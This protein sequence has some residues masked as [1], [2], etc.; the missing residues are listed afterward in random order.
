MVSVKTTFSE[1]SK[2]IEEYY[3]FINT[4]IATS[5]NDTLN[6][7]LKSNLLLMLYNLVEST[8]SN[9]V[10]EIH[11]SI[12]VTSTSFNSLKKEIRKI[13]IGYLKSYLNPS[14]FVDS[15]S[16]IS[17]DIIKKC[18]IKQKI[19]SGN[20]D[21]KK[22]RELSAEYGFN[23]TTDYSKTKNGNC[24]L[25]IKGKRNDLAHGV[26]S[27]TEVG[28]DYSIMDL[29]KMKDETINYL[30]EI[31]TNIETYLTNKEYIQV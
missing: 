9:A 6:K 16:D 11:N 13:L 31:L 27:F 21:G 18:F 20:I 15:I 24:L 12:H 8:M 26:F 30:S 1:R 2:E 10:E 17:V 14:D 28:K 19:F 4:F 3:S 29:E 25:D 23:S 5:K 22:I 7:I